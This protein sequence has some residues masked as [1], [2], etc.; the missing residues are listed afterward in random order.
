M[1]MWK[2]V[3]VTVGAAS[4]AMTV[5]AGGSAEAAPRAE[6]ATAIATTCDGLPAVAKPSNQVMFYGSYS[7]SDI[8]DK[9]V[10]IDAYVDGKFVGKTKKICGGVEGNPSNICEGTPYYLND[11]PG[12]QLYCSI[13]HAQYLNGPISETKACNRY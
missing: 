9:S 11:G 2:N 8:G 12:V 5:V 7:C 3:A 6:A 13:V 10:E 1:N 4:I